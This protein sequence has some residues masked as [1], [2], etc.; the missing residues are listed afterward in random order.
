MR[1][2]RRQAV[3]PKRRKE[4]DDAPGNKLGSHGKAVLLRDRRI[5]ERIEA[6]SRADKESLA[7][8]AEKYLSGDSESLNI[9]RADQGLVRR[10]I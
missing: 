8:Q 6:P 10:Q 3:E 2:L 5:G 9:T 7:V 1:I 4:A